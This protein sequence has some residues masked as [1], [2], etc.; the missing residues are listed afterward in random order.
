M[1]RG[2]RQVTFN[3]K[4]GLLANVRQSIPKSS[5]GKN[6]RRFFSQAENRQGCKS[7]LGFTCLP[8]LVK[9]DFRQI[10]A[11]PLSRKNGLNKCY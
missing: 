9:A 4:A 5:S 10:Q 3:R 8:S 2:G 6:W 1:K 11:Y 7:M